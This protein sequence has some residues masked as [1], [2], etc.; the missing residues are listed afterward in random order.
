MTD[1]IQNYTTCKVFAEMLNI[2]S[3]EK[4]NL[5]LSLM[6]VVPKSR[7]GFNFLYSKYEH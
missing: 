3:V 5:N 4:K 7:H 1:L 2:T 6:Y